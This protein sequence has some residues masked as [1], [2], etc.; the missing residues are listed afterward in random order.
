VSVGGNKGELTTKL[1]RS[2]RKGTEGWGEER[3]TLL[4]IALL[5]GARVACH[6]DSPAAEE[7]RDMQVKPSFRKRLSE[8]RDRIKR[9]RG[10]SSFAHYA[11]K[12]VIPSGVDDLTEREEAAACEEKERKIPFQ[13]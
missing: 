4:L 7:E 10:K 13:A 2:G 5:T 3:A 12:L 9:R 1:R 11:R 6:R 8:F